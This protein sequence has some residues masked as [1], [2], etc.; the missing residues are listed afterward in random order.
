M[1]GYLKKK[2][3]ADQYLGLIGVTKNQLNQIKHILI[4]NTHIVKNV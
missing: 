4:E 2:G 1:L 3:G